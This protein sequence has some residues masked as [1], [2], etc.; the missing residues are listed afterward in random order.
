MLTLAVIPQSISSRADFPPPQLHSSTARVSS[1]VISSLREEHLAPHS[2]FR[3][4][5]HCV[6]RLYVYYRLDT[7][8]TTLCLRPEPTHCINFWVVPF[9]I[10]ITDKYS[11]TVL[12][13]SQQVTQATFFSLLQE[14][15]EYS[16]HCR[17]ITS[18]CWEKTYCHNLHRVIMLQL[19]SMPNCLF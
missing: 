9:I 1:Q 15:N 2:S 12:Q 14:S 7:R 10:T 16:Q 5:L 8:C 6:G 18:S 3:V 11:C 13:T 4:R 17:H 19:S